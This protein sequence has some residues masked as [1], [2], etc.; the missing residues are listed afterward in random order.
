MKKTLPYRTDRDDIAR[1]VGRKDNGAQAK[2]YLG[3]DAT[4]A[5]RRWAL[6]KKLWANVV[7]RHKMLLPASRETDKPAW[8]ATVY[9]I[10]DSRSPGARR[11]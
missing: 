6:L 9:P 7:A 4:E 10:A 1:Y 3:R 8:T 11:T 2:F 5:N